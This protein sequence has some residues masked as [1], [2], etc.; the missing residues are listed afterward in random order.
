MHLETQEEQRQ[1]LTGAAKHLAPE[2]QL[3]IDLFNP[4]VA[5]PDQQQEGQLFLHCLKT[6]PG[7]AHVLHFQSPRVDRVAQRVTMTNY[8]DEM[9]PGGRVRRHLAP[10]SLRYLSGAELA[11]LLNAAGLRVDA[12]YGTYELDPFAADSPRLIVLACPLHTGP[13]GRQAITRSAPRVL[14]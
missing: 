11:L 2:G 3:V 12:L 5:L 10:F 14:G 13:D 4:D 6:L 8:Y 9:E 7:G 1:A